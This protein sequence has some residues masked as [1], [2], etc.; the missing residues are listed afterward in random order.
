MPNIIYVKSFMAHQSSQRSNEMGTSQEKDVVHRSI[1][2]GTPEVMN[3]H[4]RGAET[5]T[6]EVPKTDCKRFPKRY[7]YIIRLI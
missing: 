3:K 2:R 4:L 6:S 7:R 1:E 5:D